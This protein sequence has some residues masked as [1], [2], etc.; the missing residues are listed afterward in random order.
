MYI[1]FWYAMALGADVGTTPVKRRVLAHDFAIFRD[2]SGKAHV[3]SDT[4][5][6]RGGMLSGGKVKGDELQ[7]PYHGWRFDGGGACKAIPSLGKGSPVPPRA[8]VDAYP[9]VEKY[10]IIFA[11]LG[12]L[13]ESERPPLMP[14]P[15]WE[16]SGWRS[17]PPINYHWN[18][19]YERC[20]ENGLDP[21][22]NE[23]VHPTHGFQGEREEE[24]KV[25]DLR[26][27]HTPWGD[28][29]MHTFKAPPGKNWL[30][31]LIRPTE[32]DLEAGTGFHGPNAMWTYI[33]ITPKM[34]VHQYVW[35]TPVDERHVSTFLVSVRNFATARFFD[36]KMMSRNV[37][38]ANQDKVICENL[39]PVVTPDSTARELMVPA[40]KVI[41]MY[42]NALDRWAGQGWKLDVARLTA[43]REAGNVAYA[44]PSPARRVSRNWVLEPAPLVAAEPAEAPVKAVGG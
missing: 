20:I 35:D 34:W 9:T 11:F 5:I 14:V 32:G 3:L 23:Y 12:D 8:K 38:V 29:F 4:C 15:E 40:D 6:H 33:H 19:N 25:N 42:R 21:A 13:A 41:M 36:R 1:N 24:Y 37:A 18:A 17:P 43:A 44:I 26:L 39:Q 2:G 31:R 16:Q 22:H 27:Q 28:G 7:C 10:G 30:L